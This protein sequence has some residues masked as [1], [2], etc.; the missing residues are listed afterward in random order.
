MIVPS[1]MNSMADLKGSANDLPFSLT[2][3]KRFRGESSS[4]DRFDANDMKTWNFHSSGGFSSSMSRAVFGV[5]I[6]R[7]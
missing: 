4:T 3:S 6:E 1:G 7:V 5:S 2:N